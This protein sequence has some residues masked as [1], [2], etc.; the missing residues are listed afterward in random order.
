[1]EREIKFRG[2]S[3]KNGKWLYGYLGEARGKVLQSIYKEKVIFE[4]LEWFNTDNFGFVVNDC[5]VDEDTI[6]QFTGLYDKNGKEIYEGDIVR[7]YRIETCGDG[8]NEPREQWIKEIVGEVVYDFGMFYVETEEVPFTAP[9]S[10]EGINS[11][12]DAI[13][14]F[15]LKNAEEDEMVDYKGTKI[16]EHIVG[17]EVIGN[18]YD[19][20]ELLGE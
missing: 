13:E 9:I 1:M 15:G 11:L 6:G 4:N 5:I 10:W 18:I 7:F 19:N 16:D 2:K 8:W 3:V 12:K 17:I 20:N 14:E